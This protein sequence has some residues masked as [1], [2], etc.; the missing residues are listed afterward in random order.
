MQKSPNPLSAWFVWPFPSNPRSVISATD[1]SVSTA[2]MTTRAKRA[3]TTEENVLDASRSSNPG[4]WTQIWKLSLLRDLLSNINA[5]TRKNSWRQP[6]SSSSRLCTRRYW[7]N[8]K[9]QKKLKKNLKQKKKEKRKKI[10]QKIKMRWTKGLP[11]ECKKCRKRK[12]RPNLRNKRKLLNRKRKNR[13]SQRNRHIATQSWWF[14][15]KITAKPI[16]F[17][18][19]L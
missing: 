2:L 5:L 1:F 13:K 16:K 11:K 18:R 17:T 15:S 9:Q 4:I 8:K 14:I 10:K 3:T 19:V 12:S 6:R 7:G